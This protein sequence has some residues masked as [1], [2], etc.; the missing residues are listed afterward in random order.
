AEVEDLGMALLELVDREVELGQQAG[1]VPL[2]GELS[3]PEAEYAALHGSRRGHRRCGGHR[4]WNR[5]GGRRRAPA[6]RHHGQETKRGHAAAA[7]ECETTDHQSLSSSNDPGR[8]GVGRA[9]GNVYWRSRYGPS[10]EKLLD[11]IRNATT[12][13]RREGS[14]KCLRSAAF[15]T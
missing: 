14:W 3:A 7:D 12:E 11:V 5:G 10:T 9:P 1:D 4:R 6:A 8:N 2:A 13:S 15:W